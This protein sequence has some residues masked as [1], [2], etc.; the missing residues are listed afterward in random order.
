MSKPCPWVTLH[1]LI[2]C[3]L[4]QLKKQKLYFVYLFHINQYIS[5]SINIK[6]F[7]VSQ[8]LLNPN[9][10][11]C[12]RTGATGSPEAKVGVRTPMRTTAPLAFF[13]LF[14]LLQKGHGLRERL[15]VLGKL[16]QT[17]EKYKF[18]HG[19]AM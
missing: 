4:T 19:I 6:Q 8:Q 3:I 18:L 10:G 15:D 17:Q 1:L 12:E 7:L 13:A 2:K 14:F 5:I 16:R 11:S 9:F